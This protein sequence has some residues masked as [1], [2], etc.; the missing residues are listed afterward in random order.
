ML[1]DYMHPLH[2]MRMPVLAK[3]KCSLYRIK[4]RCADFTEGEKNYQPKNFPW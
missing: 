3:K 4:K 1:M 2:L